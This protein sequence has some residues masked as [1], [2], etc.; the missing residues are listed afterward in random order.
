[1][2]RGRGLDF[3]LTA[4]DIPSGPGDT[5]GLGV[6]KTLWLLKFW[7]AGVL[8]TETYSGGLGTHLTTV[9]DLPLPGC[10]HTSPQNW[11]KDS[12]KGKPG[13]SCF[14]VENTA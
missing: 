5:T 12:P 9:P 10:Y 7:T 13:H 4:G 8:A 14:V 11:Y 1:M 6:E 2:E 3:T